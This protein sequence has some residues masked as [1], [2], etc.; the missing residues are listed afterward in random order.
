MDPF[1]RRFLLTAGSSAGLAVWLPD[2]L[3]EAAAQTP[4][5]P[6]P[7]HTRYSASSPQGKA[8][9]VKYAT[10]VDR[11][12]HHVPKGDPRNWE[13]QWYTHWIPGPGG[14]SP[15]PTVAAKKTATIQQVY[16]GKPPNDP[17]RKLAEAMWDDC[18]AHGSNPNI[19]TFFEEMFFCPWHRYFVY[20][21]EQIIRAVLAD[22]SFTLPYWDYLS[23]QISDLSIPPEFRDPQ[24][25]LYRPNRNPWVNAGERIDKQNP[26]SLNLNAFLE[27][28]YIKPIPNGGVGF[29]PVLDGNPHGAVHVYVGNNTNMG[30]V[31]TAAGDPIFWL[32]HSNIDRLWE[33][34]NRLNHANPPWPSRTFPYANGAGGAVTAPVAGADRVALLHYRYDT[35]QV[36][37]GVAE[38]LVAAAPFSAAAPA[39]QAALEAPLEVV[40]IAPE[41]LTLGAAPLRAALTLP[42][43]PLAAAAA[44]QALQVSADRNYY[45]VLADIKV[46]ADPGAATYN[47]HFD[48]PEGATPSTEDPTY[49]GTLNFFGVEAGHDHGEGEGHRAA[50]NVTEAL[51]KLQA[52]GKLSDKPTVTLLPRGE[53]HDQAKPTVGELSLIEG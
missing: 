13:F 1:T 4:P 14:F 20:Y 35:Y 25:P 46:Q 49:V 51:K 22:P 52:A 26:G 38:P 43:A 30:N 7:V 44:P 6:V 16:Q 2:W 15:W 32:H 27:T 17:H 29:C 12:M 40:A 45:L 28:S 48:L 34:W 10:A 37:A 11:M 18:Q 8:M 23:G 50:F 9:L 53:G 19:P 47:V 24:S 36:P 3:R 21:F 33:S 41:P 42:A 39:A 5:L 31:P